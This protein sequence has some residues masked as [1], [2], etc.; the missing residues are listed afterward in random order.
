MA[1]GLVAQ[2]LFFQILIIGVFTYNCPTAKRA[3]RFRRCPGRLTLLTHDRI[4][5]ADGEDIGWVWIGT[6]DEYTRL[7]SS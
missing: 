6:P 3:L 1:G 4:F 2:V 5:V 7:I